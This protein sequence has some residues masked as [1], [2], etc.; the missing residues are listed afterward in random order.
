MKKQSVKIRI[1]VL[2]LCALAMNVQSLAWHGTPYI[3]GDLQSRHMMLKKPYITGVNK[4]NYPGANI[5]VGLKYNPFVS[6]E[7]G[8]QYNAKKSNNPY[9]PY[10][11]PYTG[12]NHNVRSGIEVQQKTIVQGCHAN[13]IGLLPLNT[14]FKFDLMTLIGISRL[15]TKI[16][17]KD[18]DLS[19]HEWS[20]LFIFKKGVW[21]PRLG[22]GA[23]S[24]LNTHMGIRALV[25]WEKT[26]Q[27]KHM[28]E[29]KNNEMI[30]KPCNS[31]ITSLGLFYQ[32]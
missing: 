17:L 27:F 15:Q 9:I 19:I 30:L 31:F 10:D 8:F 7:L 32:F 6:V 23:Q 18:Y 11:S 21:A 24:M 1:F 25:V 16:F 26:T 29:S 5:Y 20:R 3:G 14:S 12:T 4:N 13:L 22:I 2:F 28:L